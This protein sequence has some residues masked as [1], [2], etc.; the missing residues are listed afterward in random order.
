MDKRHPGYEAEVERLGDHFHKLLQQATEVTANKDMLGVVQ[1]A[2]HYDTFNEELHNSDAMAQLAMVRFKRE[3]LNFGA[4]SFQEK[5]DLEISFKARMDLEGSNMIIENLKKELA[6]AKQ[7]IQ[8]LSTENQI[9]NKSPKYNP[10]T[11]I[12]V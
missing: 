2:T 8:E 10:G 12:S 5:Q 1:L 3:H 7:T 4:V 6:E 9:V 11:Y